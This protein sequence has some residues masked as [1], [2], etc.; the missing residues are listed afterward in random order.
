LTARAGLSKERYRAINARDVPHFLCTPRRR[1]GHIPHTDWEKNKE[2][3]PLDLEKRQF[4]R[5]PSKKPCAVQDRRGGRNAN[6]G[7]D[8]CKAKRHQGNPDIYTLQTADKE[9]A[10]K[11]DND[12]KD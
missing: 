2:N 6:L 12:E 5:H 4:F 3:H 8:R 7:D 1:E 9:E 11:L 10:L